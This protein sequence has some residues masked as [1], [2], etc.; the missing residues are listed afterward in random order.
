MAETLII[1]NMRIEPRETVV[2]L[3]LVTDANGYALF[4]YAELPALAAHLKSLTPPGNRT[5]ARTA[6]VNLDDLI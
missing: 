5:P 6:K 3:R 1:G 2:A 4:G